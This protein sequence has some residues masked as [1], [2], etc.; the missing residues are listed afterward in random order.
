M[1]F[2]YGKPSPGDALRR[3]QALALSSRLESA[4]PHQLVAILYEELAK[5][6]DVCL[7]VAARGGVLHLNEH[8]DRAH[9][10]LI[11]L[12]AGLDVD[13]GGTIA[14]SLAT[15]YRA[16][17]KTLATAIA[18]NDAGSITDLQ[19]GVSSLAESWQNIAAA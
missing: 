8:A 14:V 2:A 4:T 12:A 3:Y 5:A 13:Q 19:T 9:S 18:T 17:S 1:A 15:V 11:A 16:M 10:I 6:L 7:A